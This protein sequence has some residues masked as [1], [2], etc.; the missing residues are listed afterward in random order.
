VIRP[1]FRGRKIETVTS[2]L[3]VTPTLLKQF[4]LGTDQYRFGKNSLNPYSPSFA[5]YDYHYGSGFVT[6]ICY[7]S[8]KQNEDH[9][10]ITTCSDSS[11]TSL[12]RKQ[13]EVFL[14]KAF[15]DFLSR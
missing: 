2:Q 3:D 1:E 13:H 6:D 12:L 15:Q 14:Q 11:G 8:R 7:I 4:H 5:Y 10:F 9:V